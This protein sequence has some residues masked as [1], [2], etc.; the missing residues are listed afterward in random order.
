MKLEVGMYARTKE[1]FIAKIKEIKTNER[2]HLYL[3]TI[4]TDNYQIDMVLEDEI[5]KASNNIIDL[6]EIG[7]YVNGHTVKM[8][9]EDKSKI[10]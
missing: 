10:S 1:G 5:S 8:I 4:Y 9:K 7:D 2:L 6:I 3:K